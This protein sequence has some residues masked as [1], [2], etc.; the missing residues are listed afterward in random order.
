MSKF[1]FLGCCQCEVVNWIGKMEGKQK[2][3]HVSCPAIVQLFKDAWS[4]LKA[5]EAISVQ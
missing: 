3:G 5:I 2:Q 1:H 4:V